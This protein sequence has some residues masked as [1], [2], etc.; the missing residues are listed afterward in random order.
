MTSQIVTPHM[1]RRRARRE[2]KRLS[3]LQLEATRGNIEA[4]AELAAVGIDRTTPL[5]VKKEDRR[6]YRWAVVVG[7]LLALMLGAPA[8][9]LAGAPFW[10]CGPG[11][12]IQAEP[13]PGGVLVTSMPEGARR[14]R[15]RTSTDV[16]GHDPTFASVYADGNDT[17]L[18]VPIDA[19]LYVQLLAKGYWEHGNP[20][21][22]VGCPTG[23]I[24]VG[25]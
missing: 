21:P 20:Y 1:L 6:R 17:P 15:Y 16:A 13:V 23:K 19:G 5:H 8:A 12:S 24:M 11:E 25:A 22:S 4:D 2:L 7:V 10:G 14:I 18:F 9:A 3:A